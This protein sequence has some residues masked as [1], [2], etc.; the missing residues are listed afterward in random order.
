MQETYNC[1]LKYSSPPLSLSLTSYPFSRLPLY[2][3]TQNKKEIIFDD[4]FLFVILI[5]DDSIDTQ[6]LSEEDFRR[7]FVIV[8]FWEKF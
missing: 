2:P 1:F 4:N 8:F 3:L 7:I 6:I 5:F